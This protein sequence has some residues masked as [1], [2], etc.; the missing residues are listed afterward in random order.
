M[1]HSENNKSNI[2]KRIKLILS[3]KIVLEVVF[4]GSTFLLHVIKGDSAAEGSLR[5][6]VPTSTQVYSEHELRKYCIDKSPWGLDN[7]G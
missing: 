6:H 1:I 2:P 4:E 5:S 3:S 7:P